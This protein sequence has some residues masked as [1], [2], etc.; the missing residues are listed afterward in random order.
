LMYNVMSSS[1]SNSNDDHKVFMVGQN[2]MPGDQTEE[3][4]AHATI[5]ELMR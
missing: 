4:I 5:A 1:W 2:D 3:E